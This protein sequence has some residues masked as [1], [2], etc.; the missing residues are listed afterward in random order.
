M[1]RK[2]AQLLRGPKR[3][4]FKHRT[5]PGTAPGTL[6]GERSNSPTQIRMFRYDETNLEEREISVTESLPRPSQEKV[7]WLDV[8]G[9]GDV[10]VIERLG[11]HF[12]IHPLALEDIVHVHQRPKTD[13][14]DESLFI[15]VRMPREETILETEQ[16]SVILGQGFVITF[17]Q[18]EGDTFDGVR[19]RIREKAR[20][21]NRKAD[22]LA[23][24]L[25][26]SVIDSYFPKLE[27]YGSRLDEL[28]EAV[29]EAPNSRSLSGLH[30]IR[31]DLIHV[32]KLMWH[33]REAINALVRTERDLISKE[34]QTYL[35]DC[36]DHVVQLMDVAE[37]DRDSCLSLQELYLSEIGQR[38]NEQM[39]TLTLIATIFMPM[40]FVAGLYG[41]NFDPHASPWNMP[42]LE[43][44]YGYPFALGLMVTLGTGMLL[45]F[46]S[47][48]W[49]GK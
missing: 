36:L 22:Y 24:A 1:I 5:K 11:Q 18:F 12:G 8:V 38:T 10:N 26:D 48:G 32:R 41:M 35:R 13:D 34:T 49:I 17:Q 29:T 45:Y 37:N 31:R 42:E 30:K 47:R 15:V 40:S 46:L 9:L 43:W 39:K 6:V 19:T 4:R 2:A 7:L 14:Y 27:Y 21:R 44:A 3:K 20:I 23:Y 16:L 33:H 28:D 25:L